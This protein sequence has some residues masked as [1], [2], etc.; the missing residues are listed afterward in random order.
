M[1]AKKKEVRRGFRPA[2]ARRRASATSP[3]EEAEARRE[4]K[5]C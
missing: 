1:T 2:D 3:E 5:T 4:E